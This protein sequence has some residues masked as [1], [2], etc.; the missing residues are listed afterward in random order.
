MKASEFTFDPFRRLDMEWYALIKSPM[1]RMA[2]SHYRVHRRD[3]RYFRNWKSPI[4]Y[5][6]LY[7]MPDDFGNRANP[8]YCLN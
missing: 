5:L 2:N 6:P 1:E 3:D 7:V 8:T 4:R